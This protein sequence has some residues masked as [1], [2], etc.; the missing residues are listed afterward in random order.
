MNEETKSQHYD[1]GYSKIK[2]VDDE[3]GRRKIKTDIYFPTEN[4]AKGIILPENSTKEFPVIIFGHA[5]VMS[6]KSYS[7]LVDSF[8]PKGYIF[9]FPKTERGISPS[10]IDL[11]NDLVFVAKKLEELN[12]NSRSPFYQRISQNR[13]VMGHSMGGGSAILAA[14]NRSIFKGLIALTPY[15]TNPSAIKAA[16]NVTIPSLIF[17]GE[18]DCITPPEEFHVPIFRALAS[19]NRTYISIS[20]GSHC[21]MAAKNA[22]CNFGEKLCNPRPEITYEQQHNILDKYITLWLDIHIKGNVKTTELLNKQLASD[23]DIK[24]MQK[25]QED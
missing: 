3:R 12:N 16:A 18:N 21:Q 10:H 24:Y 15:E 8:V 2:F 20:G 19:K 9:A 23:S 25:I 17:S 7:N 4:K 11:A 5:F 22:M 14:Q 6:V 1:V 13:C